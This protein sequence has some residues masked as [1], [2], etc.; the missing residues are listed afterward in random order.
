[1]SIS[2]FNAIDDVDTIKS[3]ILGNAAVY[4]ATPNTT[5]ARILLFLAKTCDTE[6]KCAIADS[7]IKAAKV[8]AESRVASL[9]FSLIGVTDDEKLKAIDA[10][11]Q[12]AQE[13][14]IKKDL[15]LENFANADAKLL[16]ELSGGDA[17]CSKDFFPN[18]AFTFISDSRNWHYRKN[19]A[20]PQNINAILH[21]ACG[22][23]Q[24]CSRDKLT[25]LL[26]NPPTKSQIPARVSFSP[27]ATKTAI[28]AAKKALHQLAALD[29]YDDNP[30]SCAEFV[31]QRA[32]PVASHEKHCE[33]VNF[34]LTGPL[35]SSSDASKLKFLKILK[36]AAGFVL[37]AQYRIDELD[38]AS[39]QNFSEYK[40]I[41]SKVFDSPATTQVRHAFMAAEPPATHTDAAVKKSLLFLIEKCPNFRLENYIHNNLDLFDF[42]S[43][44]LATRK[45]QNSKNNNN[46]ND[47][48]KK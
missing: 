26:S 12:K 7:E 9:S 25:A 27:E 28:L 10:R 6:K 18:E 44:M 42:A 15:V 14:L 35:M 3:F 45:S 23:L 22:T 16:H 31:L 39:V 33:L 1:M 48:L 19:E 13:D 47:I 34:M 37:T 43:S 38:E 8:E 17:V 46:N 41:I 11:L 5:A 30:H 36:N 29:L 20:A 24:S 4:A 21:A 2:T 40:K 32:N